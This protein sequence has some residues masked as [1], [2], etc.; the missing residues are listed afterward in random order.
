M[1]KLVGIMCI[2]Q[3]ERWGVPEL[4]CEKSGI[5]I[6]CRKERVIWILDRRKN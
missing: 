4:V 1:K 3:Q 2:L 5:G 6:E